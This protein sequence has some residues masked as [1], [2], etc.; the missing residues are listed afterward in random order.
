MFHNYFYGFFFSYFFPLLSRWNKF[1]LSLS[2]L[3]LSSVISTILLSCEFKI[4]VIVLFSSII[5]SWFF[6][7]TSNFYFFAEF[8]PFF[9][10]SRGSVIDYYSSFRTVVLRS[11]P[12]NSNIWFILVLAS[13]Q[14]FFSN[15]FS[16][17]LVWQ[18]LFLLYF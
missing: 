18:I 8:S 6:F 3:I 17:F 1:N 4:L 9:C 10:I 12:D 14:C 16:L 15:C 7:I 11:L 13:D 5:P 2:S